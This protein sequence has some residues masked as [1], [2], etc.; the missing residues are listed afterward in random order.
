VIEGYFG[1]E[2]IVVGEQ[3]HIHASTD[4]AFFRV[5]FYRIGAVQE[6]AGSAGWFQGRYALAPAHPDGVA[7]HA[8]PAVDW[9]WPAYEFTTPAHWTPGVYVAF[10]VDSGSGT[11]LVPTETGRSPGDVPYDLDAL[12]DLGRV[13]FVL[14]PRVPGRAKILYKQSSFTR[15]AYNRSDGPGTERASSLYDNLGYSRRA[16]DH[17]FSGCRDGEGCP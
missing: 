16:F 12:K 1:R 2:S 8:S 9:D 15:H 17:D 11:P 14:R 3:L 4:A 10:F 7:E 13:F 6:F 5:D